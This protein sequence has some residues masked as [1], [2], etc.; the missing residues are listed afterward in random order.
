MKKLSA[1]GVWAIFPSSFPLMASLSVA[2]VRGL[3]RPTL[4]QGLGNAAWQLQNNALGFAGSEHITVAKGPI[5][6][7]LLQTHPL[8][9]GHGSNRFELSRVP[10][11]ALNSGYQLMECVLGSVGIPQVYDTVPLLK[12]IIVSLGRSDS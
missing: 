12:E 5:K 3:L 1:P 2:C 9:E 10:R 8:S 7:V 11:E 6:K 4:P